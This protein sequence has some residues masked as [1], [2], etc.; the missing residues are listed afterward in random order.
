MTMAKVLSLPTSAAQWLFR[1]VAP[2]PARLIQSVRFTLLGGN[3]YGQSDVSSDL[4]QRGGYF[5][6]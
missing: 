4:R 3:T 5:G 6:G 1:P 2:T